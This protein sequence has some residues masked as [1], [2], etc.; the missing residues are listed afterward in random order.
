MHRAWWAPVVVLLAAC[1]STTST[2][3][4]STASPTSSPSAT[5]PPPSATPSLMPGP[6]VIDVTA[7]GL[8]SYLET[9]VPVAILHSA[10]TGEVA[11]RVTV[12]L[13]VTTILKRTVASTDVSVAS[14]GPGATVVVTARVSGALRGDRVVAMVAVGEWS[15][16]SAATP[17]LS[18][19]AG[20][21]NCAGCARGGSGTLTVS[22]SGDTQVG[23]IQVG[24][25]CRDAGGN[26]VGGGSALHA[27]GPSPVIVS[28]PI[29]LSAPV[30]A[31]AEVSATASPF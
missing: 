10:S 30:A 18:A 22:V 28:V 29:I 4:S 8:G 6:R 21:P 13:A 26:I 9:T 11:A 16:A 1:G 23:L 15:P 7:T 19:S 31:C 24:A 25:A 12:H 20:T 2:T 17:T 3:R 5:P 14:I 27:G